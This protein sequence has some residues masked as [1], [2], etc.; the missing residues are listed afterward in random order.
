MVMMFAS[1]ILVLLFA[2]S[3]VNSSRAP[4]IVFV[5]TD[6]QD[7]EIGGMNPMPKTRKLIGDAG[8]VFKNAFVTSPLCCPSRSSI[9][10]GNYAHNNGAIN[11]SLSGNCSSA[12][13]QRKSETNTFAVHLRKLGYDTFFAGKYLNQYGDKK[14][15]G[16]AHV[17]PGWKE[18]HGLVGNSKYY[19]YML[20]VNGKEEA[21]GHEYNKDYLTNLISERAVEF[22]TRQTTSTP[23][24]MMLSTPACHAPFTPAPQYNE[25][26]SNLTA[27]RNGSF[28]FYSEDKH[29]LARSV[30]HPLTPASLDVIDKTYRARW[31]T[32][33][34]VDDL[35]ERI[36]RTLDKTNLLNNTYI[37]FMSDNGYHLGQLSFPYDKRQLYEFDI[38]V[39]LMVRG[40]NITGGQ[41]RQ[42]IILNIDIAP[43]F[44]DLATNFHQP[45]PPPPGMDGQS[46]KTVLLSDGLV[47]SSAWRTEFLVEHAGEVQEV[48]S[49]CPQLSHQKVSYCFPDCVCEDSSNNTYG[50]VRIIN[51]TVNFI[52]CLFADDESFVEVYNLTNDPFQLK[53]VAHD[54]S[55]LLLMELNKRLLQLSV[56]SGSTCQQ[57][58]HTHRSTGQHS[59]D[60]LLHS[61]AV[62]PPLSAFENKDRT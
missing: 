62:Q 1:F 55:P 32:L 15:G 14:A 31:Q 39:P 8:I 19:D 41:V 18:W 60:L 38:R 5:L 45:P 58:D 33:L 11:N 30:K 4:N 48:V 52:Y 42:E 35:V 40:P 22:L 20:S 23:F 7:V 59:T 26:F 12:T 21:H 13:W 47:P 2:F 36:V 27:P 56:C 50:C 44:I 16:V 57:L 54:T 6:D 24:L 28:N 29:W 10:T 3:C 49:E 43:T 34:S 61:V 9:L 51:A 46:F 17:P 37:V 25:T 53:N